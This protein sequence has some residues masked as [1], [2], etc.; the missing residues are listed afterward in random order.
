MRQRHEDSSVRDWQR[1]RSP[2]ATVA[3]IAYLALVV[4]ASL[5]PFV[6]WRDRGIGEFDYLSA[7]WPR[8][9]FDFDLVVNVLG[10]LP[11]GLFG[12]YALYPRVRGLLAVALV[13]L[14]AALVSANL[15]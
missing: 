11:L 5:Y 10:Y 6:G 2:L 13:T 12:V 1:R 8:H 4:D 3:C 14:G 7:P 9:F 15:E